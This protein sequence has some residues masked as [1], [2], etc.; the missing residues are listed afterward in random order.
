MD[1]G[2]TKGPKTATMKP[3][4]QP[5]MNAL[6]EDKRALVWLVIESLIRGYLTCI[7][8]AIRL[9]HRS[10]GD[11]IEVRGPTPDKCCDSYNRWR[12]AMGFLIIGVLAGFG[13]MSREAAKPAIVAQVSNWDRDQTRSWRQLFGR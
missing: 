9:S 2:K 6:R 5:N 8:R 10:T 3:P 4:T 7:K 1:A 13:L 12:I 11:F